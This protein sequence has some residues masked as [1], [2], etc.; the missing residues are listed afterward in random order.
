MD[1]REEETQNCCKCE[2]LTNDLNELK[3]ILNSLKDDMKEVLDKEVQL[4]GLIEINQ[5]LIHEQLGTKNPSEVIA[6]Q[7]NVVDENNKKAERMNVRKN[8]LIESEKEGWLKLSGK[9]TFDAKAF[10][11]QVDGRKWDTKLNSWL[12]PTDG[13][14][15]LTRLFKDNEIDFETNLT[16]ESSDVS[17]KTEASSSESQPSLFRN[18]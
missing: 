7:K 2:G 3:C 16:I 13:L 5:R 17:E 11:K 1:N 4:K 14:T 12:I 6:N 15:Q 10:I 8:V 18:T 9:G